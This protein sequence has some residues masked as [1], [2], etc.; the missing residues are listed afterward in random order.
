MKI[1]LKSADGRVFEVAKDEIKQ[2]KWCQAFPDAEDFEPQ[3]LKFTQAYRKFDYSDGEHAFLEQ[4]LERLWTLADAADYLDASRLRYAALQFLEEKVSHMLSHQEIG[5]ARVLLG[6]PHSMKGAYRKNSHGQTAVFDKELSKEL[7]CQLLRFARY[8]DTVQRWRLISPDWDRLITSE[9]HRIP[10]RVIR[11]V[12]F[13]YKGFIANSYRTEERFP[14]LSDISYLAIEELHVDTLSH[15]ETLPRCIEDYINSE[16]AKLHIRQVACGLHGKSDEQLK[17]FVAFLRHILCLEKLEMRIGLDQMKML[18]N[19]ADE[20]ELPGIETVKLS[21]TDSKSDTSNDPFAVFASFRDFY[22][23]YVGESGTG[24]L[25]ITFHDV[26]LPF[27][28]LLE[29]IGEWFLH[30]GH[31]NVKCTVFGLKNCSLEQLDTFV[32]LNNYQLTESGYKR[33]HYECKQTEGREMV[34]RASV[35]GSWYE[36]TYILEWTTSRTR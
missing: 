31:L 13:T 30:Y 19:G 21:V 26:N 22:K 25:E 14:T 24:S 2:D 5:K 1:S 15:K 23:A 16:S 11:R 29:A 20:N 32:S 33:R 6:L 35:S 12:E 28:D 4:H 3:L 10:R 34:L 27:K 9:R 8:Y 36:P 7:S 17:I 18:T